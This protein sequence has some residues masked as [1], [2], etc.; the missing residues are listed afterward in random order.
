MTKSALLAVILVCAAAA[1]PPVVRVIRAVLLNDAVRPIVNTRA[2]VNVIAL[3][4]VSGPLDA[5]SLELHDSFGSLEDLDKALGGAIPVN[6]PGPGVRAAIG[7]Y[8]AGLS[9]RP[10]QWMQDL[11]KARYIDVAIYRIGP[12]EH[13]DFIK[14]LKTRRVALSSVNLD[15]PSMVYQI[16]SGEPAGTYM[17]LTALPSLRV[18]DDGKPAAPVYAEGD[19]AAARKAAADIEGASEHSLFRIE[20]KFSYVLDDFASGDPNF[21]RPGN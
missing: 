15:R 19:Q 18:F 12:A 6:A 21:W 20:P 3:T 1:Q 9:Y 4:A 11:P 7:R 14:L 5:W 2:T 16:V 13:G 17:V 10:E 8:Q